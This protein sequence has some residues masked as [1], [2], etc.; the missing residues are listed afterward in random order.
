MNMNNDK[1]DLCSTC[2]RDINKGKV[3]TL[4]LSNGFYYADIPECLKKSNRIE[5]RLLALRHPFQQ[6]WTV[7]GAHGQFRSK[8]AINNIPV[9]F[10]TTVKQ[11]PRNISDTNIIPVQLAKK[12]SYVKNYM[13]G[14][15][16]IE[17][18]WQAALFLNESTCYK[19]HGATLDEQWISTISEHIRNNPYVPPEGSDQQGG[20]DEDDIPVGTS[21]TLFGG[22]DGIRMAPGEKSTPLSILRDTDSD[23]LSFPKVLCGEP[24]KPISDGKPVSYASVIKSL[25]RHF[26]RR[27]VR[28]D[29]LFYIDAKKLV[30]HLSSKLNVVLRQSKNKQNLTTADV[31]NGE[32]MDNLLKKDEAFKI[33]S[34]VR[35]SPEYWKVEKANVMAMI[36]QLDIPT[37][38][39][40]LSAAE[41][42]WPELLVILKKVVDSVVISEDDTKDL[43]S[44]EIARLIQSDAPTCARYFDR[45]FRELKSTWKAPHGP[46][47]NLD[48]QNHYYRI[49]FQARGSPH[50]HMLAWLKDAP[51]Y[52]ESN[53]ENEV[54]QFVDKVISCKAYTP[55]ENPLMAELVN[56]RQRHKHTR[57]CYKKSNKR[58]DEKLVGLVF[59]FSQWIRLELCIHFLMKMLF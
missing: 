55:E 58:K 18:V 30:Q 8:G 2:R 4:A 14:N 12:M 54:C 34:S 56:S 45:R 10:D 28:T 50:V 49:E 59:L 38:F 47:G 43:T 11:F 7:A 48:L 23:F 53:N 41:T 35:S 46:F 33:F 16:N 27:A 26:D 40:T 39:I 37:L 44:S 20:I 36:R 22:S 31:L 5:E 6:I 15:V 9:D 51:I 1:V 25:I 42:K 21:E 24:I 29:V 19:E 3:P 13:E 17:N 52:S 32:K 57:T